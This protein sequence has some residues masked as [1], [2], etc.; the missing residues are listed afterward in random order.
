MPPMEK[1]KFLKPRK[2]DDDFSFDFERFYRSFFLTIHFGKFVERNFPT[3][4][5]LRTPEKGRMFHR[6]KLIF[7]TF[8]TKIAVLSINAF[9]ITQ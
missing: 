2:V 4:T 6:F 7:Q 8:S 5:Y 3:W 1:W 9:K